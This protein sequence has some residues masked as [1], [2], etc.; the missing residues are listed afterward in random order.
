M[1]F[2]FGEKQMIIKP[3]MKCDVFVNKEGYIVIKQ[4]Y[5]AADD[6]EFFHIAISVAQLKKINKWVKN[7][8]KEIDLYWQNGVEYNDNDEEIYAPDS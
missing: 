1:G 2:F 5:N 3:E 6:N 8:K 7:N 4:I